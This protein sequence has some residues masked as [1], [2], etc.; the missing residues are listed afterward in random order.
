VFVVGY[1]LGFYISEDGN[2]HSHRRENLKSYITVRAGLK[3]SAA[4]TQA[5]WGSTSY[6]RLAY[7]EPG[8]IISQIFP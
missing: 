3:V 4:V 5:L 7:I 2:L 1:E 8:I 6:M